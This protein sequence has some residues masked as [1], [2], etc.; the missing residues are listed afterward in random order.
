M[1]SPFEWREQFQQVEQLSM[2]SG[3]GGGNSGD[4]PDFT[5]VAALYQR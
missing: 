3:G 1:F 2:D 5:G 4:G